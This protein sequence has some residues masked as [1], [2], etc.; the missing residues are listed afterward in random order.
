MQRLP[1]CNRRD[2]VN[3]GDEAG[4]SA[5]GPKPGRTSFSVKLGATAFCARLIPADMA[6]HCATRCA[7]EC[8]LP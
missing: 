5:A 7:E 2:A 4:S 3:A 6:R 1:N 8:E